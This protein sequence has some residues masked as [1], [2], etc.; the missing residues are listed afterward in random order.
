MN[1]APPNIIEAANDP[2]LFG[3]YLDGDPASWRRWRAIL[4]AVFGVRPFLPGDRGILKCV[5]SR[6]ADRMPADGFSSSMFV[7]GR[8][9]GKSRVAGLVAAYEAALGG[10]EAKLSSGE[11]G[12][13]A[14]LA[15]TKSQARIVKGYVRAAFKSPMLAALIERET[16][17]GFDLKS[18]ISV[19]ILTGDPKTVRGYTLVAA[20][21]DELAFFGLDA[22][23]KVRSADELLRSLRPGL[24]TT[25]GRLLCITTP[26]SRSGAAWNLYKKHYG[27]NDS[28]TLVVN[29]ASRVLNPTLPQSV[30]SE[31]LAEDRAA[32]E[33]EF[34]ARFRDDVA[35]FVPRS[36]V[37]NLVDASRTGR[38]RQ[39]GVKY[40]CFVD[41]SGGRADDAT[42]AIAHRDRSGEVVIDQLA[43]V[44]PPFSP[45]AVC[46]QFSTL[47][48]SYGC[49]SV[50]GDNYG[51][52]FVA[53]AFRGNGVQYTRCRFPKAELYVALLPRL[54]SAGVVLPPD[55]ALLDQFAALERKTRSGGRDAIDH[56]NGGHDDL[57]NSVAGVVSIAADPRQRRSSIIGAG[58]DS[59]GRWSFSGTAGDRAALP[60]YPRGSLE[61]AL[62][63]GSKINFRPPA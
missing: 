44:R 4:R 32:A 22:E 54:C 27:Q 59:A 46:G 45:A 14:V 20:V 7:C 1:A 9:S 29:A 34:L 23:S 13:V 8:R 58:S 31:A 19:E 63:N 5:A 53:A 26:Y 35:Q 18:G 11:R 25:G 60:E 15:P 30:V 12:V 48:K 49:L 2:A 55:D 62:V 37:E 17:T 39:N 57:V 24:A 10:H 36:L 61:A 40:F 42:A 47:A 3:N 28:A 21:V 16:A 43:R 33:A 52:E 6:D 56:P 51:A 41:I 50:T 38:P